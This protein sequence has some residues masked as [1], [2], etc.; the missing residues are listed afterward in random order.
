[1]QYYYAMTILRKFAEYKNDDNYVKQLDKQQEEL[2]KIIQKICY[3]EDRFIRG[4]TEEG[5]VIGKRTEQR[6]I[7]GLTHRAGL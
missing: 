6:R 1:M 5:N 2:G 4:F 7:C 3:D